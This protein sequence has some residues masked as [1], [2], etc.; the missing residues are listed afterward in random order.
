MSHTPHEL[1][2]EFP[3][4]ADLIRTL[5]ASDPHFAK[6]VAE[7]AAINKAV[8]QAETLTEPVD[9]L[10]EVQMRKQRV[11]LKDEIWAALSTAAV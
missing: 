10:T 1:Q 8:H 2:E 4:H 6:I 9:E 7:Y 11:L 3:K 5:T